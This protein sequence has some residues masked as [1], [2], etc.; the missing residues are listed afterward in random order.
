MAGRNTFKES[1]RKAGLK[2]YFD[3][4]TCSRGHVAE[5]YV[6]NSGCVVCVKARAVLWKLTNQEKRRE[7]T[8]R[9]RDTHREE[10]TLYRRANAPRQS[11]HQKQWWIKNGKRILAIGRRQRAAAAMERAATMKPDKPCPKCGVIRLVR[12]RCK[13]CAEAY[14]ALPETKARRKAWIQS[15][16]GRDTVNTWWKKERVT[17][18]AEVFRGYGNQC[19]CCGEANPAFFQI[20]HVNNDGAARRREQKSLNGRKFYQKIIREGFPASLQI[21]CANCNFSKRFGGV[22]A[23]KAEIETILR[24]VA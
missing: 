5:R 12:A 19:A 10:A 4:S 17:L 9:Y 8:R 13:P 7:I 20:D 24:I 16:K 6:D 11:V 3:N 15:P 21:L 18:K 14:R 23:H 2:T 22:C 1:A